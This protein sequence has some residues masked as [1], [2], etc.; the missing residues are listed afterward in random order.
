MFLISYIPIIATYRLVVNRKCSFYCFLNNDSQF[1]GHQSGFPMKECSLLKPCH[2]R[3]WLYC[4]GKI[5]LTIQSVYIITDWSVYYGGIYET[6]RKNRTDEEKNTPCGSAGIWLEGV[7]G[8]ASLN[9]ICE[10]GI[11]K[12]SLYHNFKNKDTLYLSCVAECFQAL[13]QC[14]MEAEIDN[15]LKTYMRVRMALFNAHEMEVRI[16]S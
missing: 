9:A 14:L 12:G 5:R 13:T 4:M 7:S 8:K 3:N 10:A 15:D 11:P 16:F 2:F 1:T 6:G